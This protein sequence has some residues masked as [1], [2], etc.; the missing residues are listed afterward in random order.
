MIKSKND[1]SDNKPPSSAKS[2]KPI[3]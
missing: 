3:Q 2:L 1:N